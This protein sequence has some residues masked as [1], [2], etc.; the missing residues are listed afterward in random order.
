MIAVLRRIWGYYI[1]PVAVEAMC[2]V[3]TLNSRQEYTGGQPAV[4]NKMTRVQ[5]GKMIAFD[6]HLQLH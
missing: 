1:C 5:A 3:R 4:H 2:L 6:R